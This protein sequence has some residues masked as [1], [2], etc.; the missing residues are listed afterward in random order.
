MT[1]AFTVADLNQSGLQKE[2]IGVFVTRS[3]DPSSGRSESNTVV[4]S[5]I[6]LL[7]LSFCVLQK[8]TAKSYSEFTFI[9][10]PRHSKYFGLTD[11]NGQVP[12]NVSA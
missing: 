2:T 8:N 7:F 12:S 3:M 1:H 10:G 5:H 9:L 6:A 4:Q 11:R